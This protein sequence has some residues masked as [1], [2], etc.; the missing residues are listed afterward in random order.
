MFLRDNVLNPEPKLGKSLYTSLLSPSPHE[1][2]HT[3]GDV[4]QAYVEHSI[5]QSSAHQEFERKVWP[6][7]SSGEL[8][9]LLSLQYTRF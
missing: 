8:F 2:N 1:R 5:V 6:I 3:S 7:V 4:F 9:L